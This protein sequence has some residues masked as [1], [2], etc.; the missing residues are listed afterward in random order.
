M[1]PKVHKSKI[2][3][4]DIHKKTNTKV[5]TLCYIGKE[6]FFNVS[7]KSEENFFRPASLQYVDLS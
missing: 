1:R 3:I 2:T 4:W 5:A 7:K 6:R